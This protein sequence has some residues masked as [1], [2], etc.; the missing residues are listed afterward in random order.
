MTR[1]ILRFAIDLGTNSIGWAILAG[2]APKSAGRQ[3]Q[4]TA[5]TEARALGVRIFPDGRNPKDGSSLAM[6]RRAPKAARRRRDRFLQRQRKLIKLLIGL[7]LLPEREGERKR[8]ERLDPYN[9]RTRGLD[10]RLEPHEFGRA[11]FHL[12]QRRG[13]QSNRKADSKDKDSGVLKEAAKRLGEALAQDGGRTLGEFLHKRLKKGQEAR[14]RLTGAEQKA[15]HQFYPTRELV[16]QEFDK[17]WAAQAA[18]HPETL[19]GD[20]KA[21]TADAIFHQRPLKA[22][23]PG[24]CTLEPSEERLPAA[25]PSVQARRIFQSLN[26]LRYGLGFSLDRKLTLDQRKLLADALLAGKSL[27]WDQ[28]RKAL[29][30]GSDIRFSREEIDKEIEGCQIAKR[31]AGSVKRKAFGKAWHSLP[32]ERKDEIVQRLLDEEDEETLVAWLE[33][34]CGV[35]PEEATTVAN[36]SLPDGFGQLGATA[37]AAVLDELRRDVVTYAEAAKNA[38]YHHSDFSTDAKLDKLPYYA[39]VLERHVAFGTGVATDPEDKRYGRIANPTVHIGLNQLRRVVNTLISVYGRPDEIVIELARELKLT[40]KQKE[41]EQRKNRDN[42]EANERRK[43]QLADL[44]IEDNGLNRMLLR[45]WEEQRDGAHSFCP[46]WGTQISVEQLFSEEIEIDHILPFSRTLDDSAANKIV[47]FREANREKRNRPPFEA[48]GHKASWPAIETNA[49]KLPGN[50]RWRF[51]PD[52]MERFQR[53]GRDFL[54]R[55]LNETKHLARVAKAYLECACPDVWVVTG[56]LTALLR[57][58]WGLDSI[59]SDDNRKNRNDHRHHAIDAAA[60][61][62]ISRGLLNELSRRAR[63]AEAEDRPRI[64]ADIRDPFEG[65]R[66]SVRELVRNIVVSHKPEHGKGGALHEDTAYGLV[67]DERER[68]IGN[69]VYRKTLTALTGNDVDRVR[70]PDLR[71]KLAAIRDAA[72][73]EGVK[74]QAAL[75]AFAERE[76][77]TEEERGAQP[78]NPIRHVRLLKPEAANIEIKDRRTGAPYKAVVPGENWCMDIVSLRDGNGGQVWK[79]FAASVFE[80]NQ[81]GW[82]PQWERDRIGAKLVMRLH[83]GDLVEIDDKDG[84]RR[85]KRVVRLSPSNGVVYLVAHNEAGDYQKRHDDPEDPFRWD[86]ANIGGM[87]G[88]NARKVAVNEVGELI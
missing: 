10:Q 41:S 65:F 22:V 88:R 78:R 73:A 62:C 8:L 40:L 24:R 32:L 64:V 42:R 15:A 16:R 54:E 20:A 50:K 33:N 11:L 2:S 56:S 25:L 84:A 34:E 86:F 7:G 80:V 30:L 37:N 9:L 66:D 76:A 63:Q 59:L 71:Q 87:R 36:M 18:F 35:G 46:Y 75:M 53:D 49:Q 3:G 61:G 13:Y 85:I 70:D 47:C 52:A 69:L 74:L 55:Q 4:T 26:E 82:R 12:N 83:K 72:K 68:A 31:L 1:P 27:S 77:R 58:K 67:R 6:M 79:G 5:I 57:N 44:G 81:R 21:R 51:A 19:T 14:F 45:L 28:I 38:G 39:K 43:K 23:K 29:R 17:L 48:F 60:I